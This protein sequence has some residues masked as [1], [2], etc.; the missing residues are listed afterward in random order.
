MVWMMHQAECALDPPTMEKKGCIHH[1]LLVGIGGHTVAAWFHREIHR[2]A[3]KVLHLGGQG[4]AGLRCSSPFSAPQG[5]G[6]S[7]HPRSFVGGEDPILNLSDEVVESA[8]VFISEK[9]KDVV[10]WICL[11]RSQGQSLH[12]WQFKREG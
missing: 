9:V 7:L 11:S 4:S 3:F 6:W 2:E 12:R 1:R 8:K 10:L 5:G